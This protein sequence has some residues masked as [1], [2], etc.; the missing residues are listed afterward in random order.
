MDEETQFGGSGD[1]VVG[2][3]VEPVADARAMPGPKT[4]GPPGKQRP[5]LIDPNEE[6]TSARAGQIAFKLALPAVAENLLMSLVGMM[7]MMMVGQ[8]GSAAIASVGATNQPIFFSTAV[9]QAL[10][11][12][13]T[14]VVARLFG[15]GQPEEASEAARQTL[16]MVSALSILLSIGL[17]FAAEPILLF[18]N[19]DADTLR[20]GVPYFKIVAASLVFGMVTMA[21]NA[22]VRGGGD[23]R[24]PMINNT[25]VN[26]VNLALNFVLINGYFGFPRLEVAGAAWATAISRVVGMVMAL[27]VV[28]SGNNPIVI[29]FKERF[30]FNWDLAKRVAMVGLPSAL[31]QF[32]MRGGNLV[33][34]VTVTSLGMQVY[35][36]HQVAM[37]IM[38]LA[39][40]PG[41]GFG[42]SA[43]TLVG[44]SLGA[45][46][47]DW[48]EACGYA[49]QKMCM[50]MAVPLM[51][52]F[53]FLGEPLARLYS[54]EAEVIQ[55]A[56]GVLKIVA[57]TQVPQASQFV[58]AGALRGAGDTRWPLVATIVGVWGFRVVLA[59]ILVNVFELGLWG[60]WIALAVD[61]LAR[62]SVNLLR[63]RSG[64]WK[65]ITV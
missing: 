41:M 6:L 23:T 27:Y 38:N 2:D 31:E 48:A 45:K 21:V 15:A 58:L 55:M 40:A 1:D 51:F 11:V 17:F 29:S 43:T 56:S 32:A 53:F 60:A 42:M 8:L 50:T 4:G 63:F 3:S 12:G 10:N 9:F 33:F 34:S 46:R 7:D 57:L 28:M 47:P 5:Q 64:K 37:N 35:A 19:A 18:M 13:T 36:A 30:R 22:Q 20:Y 59:L 25:V 61:Q 65:E 39:M 14:A 16:V 62:S 54:N 52:V 49:A 44:Q 24:T 26:L